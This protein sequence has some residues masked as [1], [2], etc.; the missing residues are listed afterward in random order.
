MIV[1]LKNKNPRI[2]S[3]GDNKMSHHSMSSNPSQTDI[4]TINKE[5]E[6]RNHFLSV[7]VNN[8]GSYHAYLTRKLKITNVGKTIE[9]YSSYGNEKKTVE[10]I[11]DSTEE[12]VEYTE[13]KVI[14]AYPNAKEITDRMAEL[15]KRNE[16]LSKTRVSKNNPPSLRTYTGTA[17]NNYSGKYGGLFPGEDMDS[18]PYGTAHRFGESVWDISN[19][20]IEKASNGK[21]VDLNKIVLSNDR[22][23]FCRKF[24]RDLF[25]NDKTMSLSKAVELADISYLENSECA[26]LFG[27]VKQTF[28]ENNDSLGSLAYGVMYALI[29]YTNYTIAIDMIDTISDYFNLEVTY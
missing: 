21:K 22:E 14:M 27:V 2:K 24:A 1:Y 8:A 25:T 12:Y 4:E 9:E 7:I 6:D 13:L 15:K 23:E 28:D 18:F 3:L 29:P 17:N 16:E 11:I 26:D 5:G 20:E 10:I 19:K